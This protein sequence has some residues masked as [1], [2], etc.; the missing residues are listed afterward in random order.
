MTAPLRSDALLPTR[1]PSRRT[2][3]LAL[4]AAALASGILIAVLSGGGTE[5]RFDTGR[6]TLVQVAS[7]YLGV[8]ASEIRRRL[9][10]GTSLAAIAATT[11]GHSRHGLLE[12]ALRARSAEIESMHL[13][14]AQQRAALQAA[15]RLLARQLARAGRGSGLREIAAGYL[16]LSEAQLAREL[17]ARGTLAAVAGAT[18]G[19]S[20][21]GLIEAIV[22]TRRIRIEHALAVKA[23]GAAQAR[24][25]LARLR[26]HAER[27]IARPAG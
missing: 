2:A 5:R 21:A 23:L 19:R 9:R 22:H 14:P 17:G 13:P 26:E 10:S 4:A 25:E 16:G 11:S 15:P 6:R 8:P 24:R 18:P 1:R 12:A 3:L 7:G 20:R 27:Q